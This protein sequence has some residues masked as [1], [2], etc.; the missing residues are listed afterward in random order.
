MTLISSVNLL[1]SSRHKRWLS[2]LELISLQGFPINVEH[3]YG[4]PTNSFAMRRSCEQLGLSM[5]IPKSSRR[6]LCHQA[7]NSMHTTISGIA[8]MYVLTQVR[9]DSE[10]L[11]LQ[12]FARQRN[13]LLTSVSMKPPSPKIEGSNERR[14]KRPHGDA[15][16]TG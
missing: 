9:I 4:K 8:L 16:P 11:K 1:M 2:P 13:A 7:G 14:R 6:A 3:S 10:T 15:F 12:I 5:G